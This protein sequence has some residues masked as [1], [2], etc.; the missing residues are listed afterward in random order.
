MDN[1]TKIFEAQAGILFILIFLL[2]YFVREKDS[3]AIQI[4]ERKKIFSSF[5][6]KTIIY[7]FLAA[8][9]VS[10]AVY[11]FAY[12]GFTASLIFIAVLGLAPLLLDSSRKRIKQEEIFSDV[13]LFCQ[14]TAMLLKQSHNV[15]SSAEKASKDL[16]TS[17]KDDI[18]SLLDAFQKNKEEVM[19]EMRVLEKSYPYSCIRNLDVILLYMFYET[20]NIDDSLLATFQDDV[21]KLEQ[22]VRKNKE[23]RKALRISYI[24]I[25]LGSILA[26]WWFVSSIKGTFGEGFDSSLYRMLCMAYVFASLLSFFFVDR[27]FNLNTTR[28]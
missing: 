5:T 4:K 8:G 20:S 27:Y 7:I 12:S 18:G 1:Y 23:K 14:N 21:T 6:P 17:L 22:D 26:Y 15:Y 28:E 24:V 13:I 3:A 2:L 10:L 9:A 11:R 16:S 25:A 19:T